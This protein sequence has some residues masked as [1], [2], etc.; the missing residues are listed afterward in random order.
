[1]DEWFGS[2]D[3]GDLRDVFYIL[4]LASHAETWNNFFSSIQYN[5]ISFFFGIIGRGQW[6]FWDIWYISSFT[7]RHWGEGDP[8]FITPGVKNEE[9][10]VNC[11]YRY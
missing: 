5:T 1:M 4:L 7:R 8:R 11:S 6:W 10:L 9:A 3:D 2:R